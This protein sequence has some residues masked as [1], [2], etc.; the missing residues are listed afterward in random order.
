M[1]WHGVKDLL[2]YAK[3][4][5][6]HAAGPGWLLPALSARFATA[7]PGAPGGGRPGPS[8]GRAG[9][10]QQ[11][12]QQKKLGLSEVNHIVAITSAKGG[13]GKS[14]TAGGQE[15]WVLSTG[16]AGGE[17]YRYLAGAPG[18]QG[19]RLDA[20]C[21]VPFGSISLT[22]TGTVHAATVHRIGVGYDNGNAAWTL[23]LG[24]ACGCP[25]D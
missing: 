22:H 5:S 21:H 17:G 13:V 18:R 24:V 9:A 19:Q 14:T 23:E 4:L 7:G 16:C 20:L 12:Q 8:A 2:S 11:P 25:P 1:Q 10:A 15:A 3:T 6:S